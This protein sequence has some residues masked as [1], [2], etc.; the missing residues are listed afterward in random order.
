MGLGRRL[1]AAWAQLAVDRGLRSAVVRVLAAN[2][3]RGFYEHLGAHRLKEARHAIGGIE[4]S[5]IWYG[6]SNL[7][8]L[9]A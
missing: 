1:V 3:A 8:D 5:E 4:Y 7:R 9:T 6:W 2:P